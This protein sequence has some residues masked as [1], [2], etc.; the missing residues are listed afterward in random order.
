MNFLPAYLPGGEAREDFSELIDAGVLSVFFAVGGADPKRLAEY[1]AAVP[2]NHS[3]Y[4]APVPEPAIRPNV[5]TLALA[6]LMVAGAV[7]TAR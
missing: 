5:E 2:G 7:H 6:V 4:F 3:P 1:E